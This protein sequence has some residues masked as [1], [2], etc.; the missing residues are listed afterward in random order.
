[1]SQLLLPCHSY[2]S[3]VTATAPLSQLLLHFLDRVKQPD[4]L[5]NMAD[6]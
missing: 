4:S 5:L 6:L 3:L 2:C 1:L